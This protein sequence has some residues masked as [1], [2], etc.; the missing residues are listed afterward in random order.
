MLF[1]FILFGLASTSFIRHNNYCN[2][3][4]NM[5][6]SID[7]VTKTPTCTIPADYSCKKEYTTDVGFIWFQHDYSSKLKL[8][9]T[10]LL[11]N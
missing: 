8:I 11:R 6:E 4:L 10:G 3:R 2:E 7:M 5:T 9:E 1:Y